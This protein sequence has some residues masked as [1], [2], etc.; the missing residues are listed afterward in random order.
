VTSKDRQVIKHLFFDCLDS[1]PQVRDKIIASRNVSDEVAGEVRRLLKNADRT[2]D[3]FRTPIS[4][5]QSGAVDSLELGDLVANRFR[6]D[7]VLG[8]GG[9]GRV[10]RATD[11]RMGRDVAI[12]VVSERFSKRFT[13]EVR[14]L[15]ALN[16]PNICI[17]H[18]VG[19]NYLVMEYIEGSPLKGPLAVAEA[20]ELARQV[21]GALEAAH[22]KGIVH[23]DLKPANILRTRDGVKLLD[24]GLA[25]LAQQQQS[26]ATTTTG[27]DVKTAGYGGGVGSSF[28]KSRTGEVLGTPAYMSPEQASGHPVDA[29]SDVF[30]LGVVL[31]EMLTGHRAFVA[32]SVSATIRSVLEK[33]P[34]P[35]ESLSEASSIVE[36][37]LRKS[38]AE[39]YQSM[40]ELRLAL[41]KAVASTT[42]KIPSIAV[43]TFAMAGA[44][45]KGEYFAEGLTQD[46]ANAL[47]A[48]PGLKVIS[49]AATSAAQHKHP[50][51]GAIAEA[52]R[53][54]HI[55]EGSVRFAGNRI[56]ITARLVT[57]KDGT[58]VW[59]K[60]FD[61]E[62]SDVF[63][64]QDEISNAITAELK[65]SLMPVGPVKAPT[66]HF[67]AYE[68]VLQGRYHFL[69]FDPAEQV[70]ALACFERAVS[71]DPNYAAAH[72][73]VAL[74]HWGQMVVG[75]V[76]P[77]Q[78]MALS[79]AAVREALR[80]DP[81]NSDGHHILASYYA[82]HDFDWTKAE[83]HFAR[84][85]DLNPN[86]LWAYHCKTIY[87]LSPMGRLEEALAC[88]TRAVALDPL[89]MPILANRAL[90]FDCLHRQDEEEQDIDRVNQLDPNFTGGQWFLVRLRIRQGRCA[91][92]I[93]IA[94]RLVRTAGRWGMTLAALGTAYA[95]AGKAEEARKV[96][97]ELGLE[98]NRESQAMFSFMIASA[99]GDL[100]EAFHWASVSLERRDPLM[101]SFI[102]SSSFEALRKDPRFVSLLKMLKISRRRS[103]SASGA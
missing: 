70:K 66:A 55:L 34:A 24:F 60:R 41:E 40:A 8:A 65:L 48:V 61:R 69:R 100:D 91:E 23:R 47:S 20:I 82:L 101:L 85:I 50:D 90:V 7:R 76:N 78:A 43:L 19:P 49:H 75:S 44:T 93:E 73:G 88:E 18:D 39:R 14:A 74:Y 86:S 72:I 52:L 1:S 92:A 97:A 31:Y 28:M 30:S 54:D 11:T 62:L 57:G 95:F 77:R 13:R 58:Q 98:P 53:V 64:I 33:E 21:A 22:S 3:T 102:W 4:P 6:I 96:L 80:L 59:S 25:T 10:Y 87:L 67:A 83:Q 26:S 38:A 99:L 84:S 36:R 32:D 63:A 12:K 71:I 89:S 35:L 46:I 56:R 29:R 2:T 68:A 27:L 103:G 16:H 37:C 42:N 9:M 15:A 81:A 45:K 94:E 17:V 51:I 79:V 5:P